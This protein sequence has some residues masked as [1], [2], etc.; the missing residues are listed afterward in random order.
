MEWRVQSKHLHSC[1]QPVFSCKANVSRVSCLLTSLAKLERQ[2]KRYKSLTFASFWVSDRQTEH[3][4]SVTVQQTPTLS[5]SKNS[6]FLFFSH[7]RRPDENSRRRKQFKSAALLLTW[8]KARRDWFSGCDVIWDAIEKK[9]ARFNFLR[10]S[11]TKRKY[12][13][14]Q[15]LFNA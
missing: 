9:L 6:Q 1:R 5:F 14:I 11:L 10:Y 15:M 4:R 8:S 7:P 2:Q 13:Y 3:L 12:K